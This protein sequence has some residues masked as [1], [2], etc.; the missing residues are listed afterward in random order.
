MSLGRTK[1]FTC[2]LLPGP[3]AYFGGGT[4]PKARGGCGL[5]LKALWVV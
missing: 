3:L 5:E 4:T 1:N 2:D